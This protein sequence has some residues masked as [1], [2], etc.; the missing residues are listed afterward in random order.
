M[1]VADATV[2]ACRGEGRGNRRQRKVNAFVVKERLKAH[3]GQ[4]NDENASL[5]TDWTARP[6]EGGIGK[7]E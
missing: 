1:A 7:V 6:L 3:D 5:S 4:M 2:D